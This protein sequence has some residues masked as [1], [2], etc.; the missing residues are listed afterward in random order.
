[1]RN[2]MQ[3]VTNITMY[4]AEIDATVFID[5]DPE[6]L[7]MVHVH[8]DKKNYGKMD[9]AMCPDF[10]EELAHNILRQVRYIRKEK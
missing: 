4:D 6:G 5:R 1:M 9:F 3:T 2:I 7:G 8:S 10:A